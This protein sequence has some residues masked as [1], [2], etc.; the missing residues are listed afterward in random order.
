M[1]AREPDVEGFV[2]RDGVKIGYEVF[3]SGDTTVVFVPI[4][5]IV[6]S[7]AWKAQVPFLAR[8]NRVITIDP[9]GNGRSDRPEDPALYGDTQYAEDTI[10]VLDA[11][12][13]ERAVLVGVCFSAWHALL[14]AAL[15]PARVQGVV[16]I[17]PWARDTVPPRPER[18]AARDRFDEVL[19]DDEGWHKMNRHYWARD[20]PGYAE[21]FFNQICSEPHSSKLIE[22]MV[23]FACESTAAVQLA[24]SDAKL[25]ASTPAES[26]AVL[27]KVECPVLVVHGTDDRCQPYARGVRIAERTGA[28]LVTL[29]GS[30]HLPQGRDPIKVNLLI[31]EFIEQVSGTTA[32]RRWTRA[33]DRRPKV[34]Y[35]SSPIGLG[36]ARRDLAIVQELRARRPDVQ[37]DWLTQDPVITFLESQ[38][39]RVHPAS[40]YLAK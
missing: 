5:V 28:R 31:R 2:E 27:D 14:T 10:A 6:H 23:G 15:H 40:S 3:G 33:L 36:H 37:V 7:R 4:D 30:G 19:D 17:G 21:F 39:E 22:D 24:E 29:E 16:A 11:L 8:T 9:R 35:L 32:P 1:R 13:I 26:D 25:Y 12:G 20:W 18:A 34:L 38:G